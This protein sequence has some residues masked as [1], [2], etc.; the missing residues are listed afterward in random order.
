MFRSLYAW[1]LARFYETRKTRSRVCGQCR[2]I[3]IF[4]FT[5]CQCSDIKDRR[6]QSRPLFLTSNEETEY[7][8][9]DEPIETGVLAAYANRSKPTE[10]PSKEPVKQILGRRIKKENGYA[11]VR[12]CR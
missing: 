10:G 4:F 3:A 12:A 9:L 11:A 6:N 1:D 7:I 8:S 5:S 2:K